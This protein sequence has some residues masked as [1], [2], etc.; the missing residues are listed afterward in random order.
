[1]LLTSRGT[2][3]GCTA[4]KFSCKIKFIGLYKSLKQYKNY[5]SGARL[6]KIKHKTESSAS[7]FEGNFAVRKQTC[8]SSTRATADRGVLCDVTLYYRTSVLKELS[9]C[10]F[11]SI[12]TKAKLN[13]YREV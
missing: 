8:I 7:D 5:L 2:R 13:T 9:H 1:M 10:I 12:L 4:S 6:K 11:I 3:Y